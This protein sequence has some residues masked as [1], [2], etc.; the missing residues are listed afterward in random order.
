ML[1]P[2]CWNPE[3]SSSQTGPPSQE[4]GEGLDQSQSQMALALTQ[5]GQTAVTRAPRLLVLPGTKLV[6]L[7]SGR[8]QGFSPPH[9]F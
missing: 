3:A 9:L 6:A 1:P 5:A 8:C 7:V 4:S 2:N